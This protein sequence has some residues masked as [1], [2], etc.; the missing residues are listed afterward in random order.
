LEE[1][2]PHP[3]SVPAKLIGLFHGIGFFIATPA[4]ES[5]RERTEEKTDKIH[6]RQADT[7]YQMPMSNPRYIS[8]LTQDT[9]ALVLAGGRGSRLH[10][11]TSRRAKPAVFFGGKFRII[12]F[13]LSNCVNSGIRRISV[14]TQYKAH[15]LIR[16]LVKGWGSFQS[17]LGEF[18]EVLPASQRTN[19]SWYAGTADAIYQNLDIIRPWRPRYILVLGGDHVYKMDYGPL[20]AQH[21]EKQADMT[22]SC[23]EVSLQEAGDFGVIGVDK[24]NRVVSFEEK[25][26]EPRPL[27]GSEDTALASMGNYVFN[28]EFLYEQLKLDAA[29]PLSSHDFSKDI[30]PSII[31][32]SHVYACPF[33]D[34]EGSVEPYWQDVGTLDAFWAA[35]MGLADVTPKLN[36]YDDQWP[37]LTYQSQLPSAKFVL[38]VNVLDSIVS[39]DCI[40]SGASLERSVL[41]S[42]VNVHSYAEVQESVLLPEVDIGRHC[43]IKRAIIDRGCL[44]ENGTILGEDPDEDAKRFRVTS[45]GI[46]LVTREM[47]GQE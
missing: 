25:P 40:V 26:A 3:V 4:D 27:P 1:I 16:H 38:Q 39:G 31:S 23:K 41:S 12:D 36:L 24:E 43:R 33:Q 19:S 22:I 17:E 7:E 10:E 44:L 15:S 47:L 46:V 18:V 30:I 29:N 20:L 14:L 37:I 5:G 42:S 34:V 8:R 32:D 21:A 11:L 28:T 6:K 45:S 9:L 13:P 2:R 35:N